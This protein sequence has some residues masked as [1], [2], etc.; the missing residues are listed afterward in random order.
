MQPPAAGARRALRPLRAAMLLLLS[1]ALV[2]CS[3]DDLAPSARI[4]T[5]TRVGAVRP[6]LEG[7]VDETRAYPGDAP[8]RQ[9]AL[10]QPLLE[11]SESQAM[12]VSETAR[13]ASGMTEVPPG[14]VD[15]DQML[16][17]SPVV[18]LAQ[19]QSQEIAEGSATQ[20]VVG[21]IGEEN[22]TLLSA[23]ATAAASAN[24]GYDPDLP[25]LTPEQIAAE[26]ARKAALAGRQQT[27][28][29]E[30][31]AL[32]A[33]QAAEQFAM[34]PRVENPIEVPDEPNMSRPA[35]PDVMPASEVAC[36]RQLTKLGVKFRD[37][38]RI[39]NGPSCGID[40]PIELTGL[41]GGIDVKPSVKLN[42]Q[43]TAAFAQWVKNE[44]VPSARY[45]YFSGVSVIK[46]LGG[47]SCRRM[48]S[49]SRGPMS[50][51]ARGNAIDVGKF[52]L[53]SGKEIDVR[54]PGF[55]AFREKGLL[56][57][58]REDSCKYFSTVLGP[59]SDPFHKDHFHFDLR[60]RNSRY[61]H[62]D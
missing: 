6:V 4:D 8:A 7:R 54:K 28:E 59:G 12:P 36:R 44:L 48:N 32:R 60:S 52:V 39:T 21:G 25:P 55:F 50:E 61:K 40:Y 33:K 46:P 22:V 13:A 19:E 1:A 43:V 57:A 5:Q 34:L 15:M 49:R 30:I 16:G 35:L 58:V 53:K 23:P 31:R 26:E 17:L 47:Y 45:R 20:P 9:A 56:K 42:C 38:A 27:R 51:H 2:A 18:G 37:L 41:S 3:T 29:A 10:D 24:P 62:C 11:P 14:G